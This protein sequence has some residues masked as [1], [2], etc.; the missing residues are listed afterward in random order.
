MN[1]SNIAAAVF[2]GLF[3]LPFCGF[4]LAAFFSGLQQ[5]VNGGPK[6]SWFLLCAG[7]LFAVLGFLFLGAA[8]FGPR[9]LGQMD[10]QLAEHRDEPWLLRGDWAQGRIVSKTR[11]NMISAWTISVL[12]NLVSIP[13]LFLV[14]KEQF[15]HDPK[16]LIALLF[17]AVGAGLLVWAVRETLRWF[18]FGKT[19]FEMASVPCVIGK[20]VCGTIQARFPHS[21]DHG[22]RLKLSCV[23]RV[24]TGSGKNESTSEK[25]VWQEQK[26][27]SAG[28]LCPGPT[29][30]AIPVSFHLPIGALQTDTTNR[31]NSIFWLLEA[32]ADVPGV[33]YKDIFELPVFRT[34]DTPTTE[35]DGSFAESQPVF[36]PPLNPTI[37]VRP[38]I[39]G[40]TEFYFPAARNKGFAFSATLFTVIFGTISVLLTRGRIPFIFPLAFGLFTALLGYISLDMWLATSSVVVGSGML[41]LRAGFLGGGKI[42]EIPFTQVSALQIAITS[43]QGGASGTPYYDIQLIKADGKKV[44]LGKTIRDKQEAEW[45]TGEMQRLILPKAMGATAN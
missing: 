34:K 25:I 18:E 44:T 14:P 16:L 10:R 6:Q 29:G 37:F 4:G 13:I 38:A 3:A 22:I 9:K 23:N 17:P 2:L 27:L 1:R 35:T 11:S 7:V 39:D 26:N 40:G 5:V 12:W 30:T 28:E 21:P 31:R 19:Y 24:V 45:I 42:N 15:L 43:Q 33:D 36:A 32:D 8:V 20:E 41:R